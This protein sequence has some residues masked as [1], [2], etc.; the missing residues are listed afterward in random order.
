MSKP[1]E[2][3]TKM[4]DRAKR[5]LDEYENER[6]A[7]EKWRLETEKEDREQRLEARRRAIESGK[8]YDVIMAAL[9]KYITSYVESGEPIPMEMWEPLLN[10]ALMLEDR[11]TAMFALSMKEQ[12][13]IDLQYERLD[14]EY[15]RLEASQSPPLKKP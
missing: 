11:H 1:K 10:I 15:A 12:A 7:R 2:R 5:I 8:L 3:R 4:N 9:M 13:D 14:P 6:A